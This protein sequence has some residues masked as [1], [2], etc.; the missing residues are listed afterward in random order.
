MGMRVIT[1]RVPRDTH[2]RITEAAHRQFTSM[3]AW[4]VDA[5]IHKLAETCERVAVVRR[6]IVRSDFQL[7]PR[8]FRVTELDVCRDFM[9]GL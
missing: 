8:V 4:L 9:P 3:N 6:P 1:L 7:P 5:V 2:Q